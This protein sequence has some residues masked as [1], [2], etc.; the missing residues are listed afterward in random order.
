MTTFRGSVAPRCLCPRAA[1]S[2]AR[3]VGRGDD[4]SQFFPRG[5]ECGDARPGT[6]LPATLFLIRVPVFIVLCLIAS[7]RAVVGLR[8]ASP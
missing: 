2:R 6:P 7:I 8:Q 4:R 5:T 3:Q 1:V